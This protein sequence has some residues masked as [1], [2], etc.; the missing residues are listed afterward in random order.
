MKSNKLYYILLF[1]SP[2]F[3]VFLVE[4]CRAVGKTLILWPHQASGN[5][6]VIFNTLTK[7]LMGPVCPR[8][9]LIY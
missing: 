1:I 6:L 7:I 5:S 8:L 4:Y 2:R 3:C 9:R